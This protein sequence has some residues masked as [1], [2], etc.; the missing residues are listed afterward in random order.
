MIEPDALG[1]LALF[2]DLSPP[3]L[4]AVAQL[5]DEARIHR[6]PN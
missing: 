2:S 1:R 3:E 4:A 6:R 5:M